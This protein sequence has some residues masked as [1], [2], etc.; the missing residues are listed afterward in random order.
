MD[1]SA[2]LVGKRI[3]VTGARGFIGGH[4]CR[5]LLAAGAEVH[6]VSRRPANETTS[7]APGLRWWQ[8]DLADRAAVSR[9]F[10]ALRPAL[11]FHLASKVAGA[12][13]LALVAPTFDA[14]LASTVHLLGAAAEM[15][16][17]RL[18]L[19]GSLEE[20]AS[21]GAA[22]VPSSPYAAAKA[23]ASAYG[24]MFH[25]LYDTPVVLARL[26]MVY[27]PAQPDHRKL[28]PYVTLSL[29]RGEAP[30]LSSGTR[31]VDWIYVEDVVAGLLAIAAAGPQLHG[32]QVD[33]GSGS[34]VTVRGVV[35]RL[36]AIIDPTIP[37]GFGDLGDRPREQVRRADVEQTAA[38][39]G[40]RPQTS[41]A[42]GL[43]ATVDWYRHAVS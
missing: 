29:L 39:I 43:R 2:H 30:Q 41:L 32:Q 5:H 36:A 34:L 9:L 26:F 40:W 12:R 25:A 28:V 1:S 23:A 42:A 20:P 4:L 18:I 31:A 19:T 3:L 21:S 38:Q 22:A 24:R 6:G 37:L 10:A 16:C 35:E 33:V 15:G 13:D 27:G 7:E 8:A 17:E 11:V 14:N